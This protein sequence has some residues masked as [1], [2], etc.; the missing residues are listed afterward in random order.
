[1]KYTGEQIE[2][3]IMNYLMKTSKHLFVDGQGRFYKVMLTKDANENWVYI[4]VTFKDDK[5][6]VTV[7]PVPT[8]VHNESL[9]AIQDNIFPKWD[10]RKSI[11]Y[12]KDARVKMFSVLKSVRKHYDGSKES[13]VKINEESSEILN[14]MEF[15]KAA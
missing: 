1:M 2:K 10:S 4:T 15:K 8:Q 3:R 14:G 7:R 12:F 13:L 11:P 9:A 6:N 5:C